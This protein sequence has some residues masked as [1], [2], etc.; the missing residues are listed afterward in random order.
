MFDLHF[1][2]KVKISSSLLV[3]WMPIPLAL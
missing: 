1:L 3:I 2:P